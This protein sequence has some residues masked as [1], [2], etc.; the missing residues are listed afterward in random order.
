MIEVNFPEKIQQIKL[1]EVF[2]VDGKHYC[3]TEPASHTETVNDFGHVIR[4]IEYIK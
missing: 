2:S 4:L 1:G 3:I